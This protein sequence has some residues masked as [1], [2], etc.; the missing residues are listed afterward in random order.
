MPIK[1]AIIGAGSLGFTRRLVRDILAVPE[2]ADVELAFTDINRKYLS[3]PER[4]C[5]RDIEASGLPARVTA[6]LRRREAVEGARYVINCVRVGGLEAFRQDIEVPLKYGVDQC[7]GD[8]LCVGGILYG[9]RG[10]PVILDFCRD[11]R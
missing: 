1:I 9:Q 2:L 11:I 7:V 5:R 10:I 3:M 6:T 8:T 4:L